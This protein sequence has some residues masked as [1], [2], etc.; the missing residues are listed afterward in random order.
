MKEEYAKYVEASPNRRDII[1]E[2][3]AKEQTQ[4][5]SNTPNDE[6][7]NGDKAAV[8]V[9]HEHSGIDPSTTSAKLLLDS[10]N[11]DRVEK[12]CGGSTNRPF[13]IVSSLMAS[14][15]FLKLRMFGYNCLLLLIN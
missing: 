11:I 9:L 3:K 7:C 2:S 13:D 6:G 12:S 15:N 14:G 1:S 10:D 8:S 5:D 4:T